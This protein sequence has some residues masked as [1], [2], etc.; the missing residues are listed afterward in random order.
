MLLD[1]FGKFLQSIDLKTYRDKFRPIKLVE[2]D[3][4]KEIQAIGMLYKV[5][6]DEKK[7]LN[8]ENFYKEY[9]ISKKVE[10]EIFRKKIT[11]CKDCFYRGLPARIYRTW[12]SIITQIHAGYVAESVFGDG[13][14]TMSA[15]LD[16]Q[17]ADFQV[18]YRGV[19]LNYQVKKETHSREVRKQKESQ[20]KL[21]GEF[22][23]ILYNVPA[24]DIFENPKTKKGEWRKPYKEFMANK[25]L[26]R[27]KNGFVVFTVNSFKEKKK[28]IDNSLK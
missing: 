24:N 25:N 18:N 15:E 3:L 1:K 26:E 22:V 28:E 5:Y 12:A 20:V 6:W 16:H 11:M 8:F 14:V 7:F 10:L 2:M 17:G 4:P 23:D 27:F 21:G 19:A 13:T 9:L